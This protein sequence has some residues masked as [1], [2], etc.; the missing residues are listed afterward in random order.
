MRQKAACDEERAAGP[1]SL[2]VAPPTLP[3]HPAVEHTKR[4]SRRETYNHTVRPMT[5]P[6]ATR[7]VGNTPFPRPHLRAGSG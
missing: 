6:T 4:K 5:R 7:A 3:T 2:K 1:E